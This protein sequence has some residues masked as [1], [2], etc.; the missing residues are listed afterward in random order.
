MKG[1]STDKV[2]DRVVPTVKSPRDSSL[3]LRFLTPYVRGLDYS[4]VFYEDSHSVSSFII[5]L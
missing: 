5:S 3:C 4:A 2:E 1:G